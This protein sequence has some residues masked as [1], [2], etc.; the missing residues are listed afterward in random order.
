MGFFEAVKSG[1]VKCFNYSG[2]ATRSEYWY[3]TLFVV[4][5]DLPFRIVA[6]FYV[7]H[8]L[9][10]PSFLLTGLRAL[11]FVVLL[12]HIAVGVRRL[13]DVDQSGWW[14]IGAQLF[15]AAAWM[16]R[17]T[18]IIGGPFVVLAGILQVVVLLWLCTAGSAGP[19]RFDSISVPE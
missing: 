9:P 10:V 4:L 17:Q 16:L 5:C 14:F 6:F 7:V 18:P 15:L 2:R 12:P 1:F 8:L 19:N 11:G 13:H 3:F